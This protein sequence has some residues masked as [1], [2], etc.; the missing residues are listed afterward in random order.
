VRGF[1]RT[2]ALWRFIAVQ[3]SNAVLV[4][5]LWG[6]ERICGLWVDGRLSG[7]NPAASS[8]DDKSPMR[9]PSLNLLPSHEECSETP[10]G[11]TKMPPPAQ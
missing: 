7:S 5:D 11:G 2:I 3:Q 10:V 8:I 4:A 9:S 6:A 1:G